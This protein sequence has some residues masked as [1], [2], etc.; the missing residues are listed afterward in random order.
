MA[1][2]APSETRPSV[3]RSDPGRPPTPARDADGDKVYDDLETD[4]SRRRDDER[5]AAIVLFDRPVR[6]EDVTRHRAEHGDFPLKARWSA[7]NGYS[8]ELT[9]GQVRALA[10]R[11]DVVHI[12]GEARVTASMATARA[13]YGSDKAAT[14]FG[15]DGDRDGSARAYGPADVATCVV[16]TGI[17]SAHVDLNQGQV[18]AWRDYVNGRTTPYDD[19]GHGTHVA[20]IVA[21][22]GDGN[23]AHRGVAPGGTLV[24]VKVLDSAGSGTSTA[25]I[26]G[27]DFCITNRAAHNIRVL[28]LSLG[29]SGSSDG[30]DAMSVAVNRA[31]ANGLLP[32]VAAGNDGPD[33]YTLG[34]PGAAG[35]ALTV[36]S[37]A[38]TG[39]K[40]FFMS[41]F[42]SRGP[43]FDGRLKPDVCGPG[44]RITAPGAGSGS[45]YVIYYGT[46]MATPFVAGVAVL[47]LDAAPEATPATLEEALTATAEDRA[48]PGAD[49]DTGAGRVQAYEAVKR[50]GGSSGT[51][52]Q[53]PDRHL[54]G[55]QRLGGTGAFDSWTFEVSSTAEPVALTLI[56]PGASASV[57]FELSLYDP[58]GALLARSQNP[59]RQEEIGVLPARTGTHRAEV[60]SITGGG[61]YFLDLSYRGPAPAKPPPPPAGP[62]VHEDTSPAVTYT[63]AWN[64]ASSSYDSGGSMRYSLAVGAAA[65]LR[66]SGTAV[67]WLARRQANAGIADVFVDGAKVASVD[68]YSPSTQFKQ[69]VFET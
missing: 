21:G 32:V 23:A 13:S 65:E 31:F 9:K 8:A 17:D 7:V 55:S 48:A 38:D 25:V 49:I 20:G 10:R 68:L 6:E 43:T 45:G 50:A 64:P 24:G 60:R 53:G 58:A 2:A 35:D 66:F 29:S 41:W 61:D 33:P 62:G 3:R 22:Q 67:K 14:D 63:G 5:V 12:E 42:S 27:V 52:P 46:S 47:M 39:E 18:V 34:S 4:L 19:N 30:A 57:D 26:S 1:H 54:T 56:V 37:L 69:V 16:D 36:C 40:G 11:P 44:H 28:N 59:D 51:G 15:V